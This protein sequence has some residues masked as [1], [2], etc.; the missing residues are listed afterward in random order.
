MFE[1]QRTAWAF[2]LALP[3]A[4]NSSA[5]RIAIMAI[6]TSNSI[7]VKPA[8]QSRPEV[9]FGEFEGGS[10]MSFWCDRRTNRLCKL[11]TH[12]SSDAKLMN[13]LPERLRVVQ[14]VP[15]ESG[16]SPRR[17]GM[18]RQGAKS[19][20][21]FFGR[22]PQTKKLLNDAG[23]RTQSCYLMTKFWTQFPGV[24]LPIQNDSPT[25]TMG[26]L[27]SHFFGSY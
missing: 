11:R 24:V 26:G 27:E 20:P 14:P 18:S 2:A 16:A 13:F 25:P 23:V 6:T 7:N 4:G 9:A 22:N 5:A 15:E 12:E 8:E 1:A 21:L 19:K 3:K 10:F 17:H